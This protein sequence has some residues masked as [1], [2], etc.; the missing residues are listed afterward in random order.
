[1]ISENCDCYEE[2]KVVISSVKWQLLR[3][4]ATEKSAICCTIT[5]L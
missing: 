2:K 4:L 3:A 1:M 5:H